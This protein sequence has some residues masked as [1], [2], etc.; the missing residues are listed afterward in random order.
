MIIHNLG[1]KDYTEIW[2]QMKAF[3]AIRDSN[4]CD[5]LWLLEHYPVYTQGQAG[6]PEHV[7]NP[8]SIKIVQSDR[9]GQVTYHGPGQLVAY[10]LMDIRRRNLGI[11]TLVAKLEEILISVLK[12]YKIPA[13]IRSG[14]PGVY[15][16]EKKI[17]SIGLRV[18]NGCTYHGIALNVNMDLSPFLGINPCGFAKMEMTQMSHFHPNIQLEEVSQHFVQYFLTQFK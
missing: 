4:S 11:R 6:K 17:A 1:I 8:N 15:V 2:E 13:N 12:H 5:E 3:T 16:G 14:A 7:L 10:V 9:G 18:K